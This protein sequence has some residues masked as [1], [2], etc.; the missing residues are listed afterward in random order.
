MRNVFWCKKCNTPILTRTCSICNTRG[1]RVAADIRPVFPEEKLL[2]ET[3]LQYPL[4]YFN[5]KSVWYTS[6][7][8]LLIDGKTHPLNKEKL[9]QLDPTEIRKELLHR[10]SNVNIKDDY[11]FFNIHISKF[12]QCNRE[13]INDIE[14]EAFEII[15]R[16]K[17]IGY[18]YIPI[19]SFSGGK[20]STVV[21]DIVRRAYA[22]PSILH[23][24][25]NTTLELPETL[26]YLSIFKK[27]NNKT[28]FIESKSKHN[29]IEL[30]KK[31]GP[32]SRV[33]RWC[34]TV[35]KTGPIGQTFSG[36]S[37]TKPILTYYGVR[38]AE[39][40]RRSKYKAIEKSPKIT[41]QTVVA[42]IINWND[43][44]IWLYI[45][46]RKLSINYAYRLGFSR[47][48]CWACP[49]N[50]SWS[51]FLMRIYHPELAEPW[52]N[53]LIQIAKE[54]GKP[55]PIEYVDSGNWKARQG[56][57][58]LKNSYKSVISS[59]P[60]GDDPFAKTYQLTKPITESLYEYF[61]PFGAISFTKGRSV[62]GEV[63]ILDKKTKDPILILQGRLGTNKLRTKIV[64]STNPRLLM[65]RIDRQIR[66]YQSCILCGGC[67]T[68]C[69]VNAIN[70]ISG[71]Y[72][73]DEQK[74]INCL[75]CVSSFDTGCLV[76]KAL[77]TK[78]GESQ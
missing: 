40:N 38:R 70:D 42:P 35:F 54:L 76:S 78:K 69:P 7:H 26:E 11:L 30:C 39:S 14:F 72:K 67:P 4:G 23:A 59:K 55:D 46:S 33:M 5:K 24:F 53:F 43:V 58:G 51:F 50:S 21:S 6:G 60:C 18:A 63:F 34:C 74:C 9:E 44:D 2:F 20:D 56:G 68:I 57:N 36:L 41:Q 28:P 65:Q 12:I 37:T 29:F 77:K 61:K 13:R 66:K 45:L 75:K 25:G 15:E 19:V 73:I 62:L 52:R 49:S 32:P 1:I 3:L 31:I 10:K 71:K 27:N 64:S 17:N 47:V 8:L 16:A 48:G 22:T